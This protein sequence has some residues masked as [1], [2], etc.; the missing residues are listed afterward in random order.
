MKNILTKDFYLQPAEQ[1]AIELLGKTL[2][3]QKTPHTVL[4]GKI[5]EVEAYLGLEDPACHSFGGK[6]TP[7]TQ[8]LYQDA[9]HTYVYLIYGMYHCMNFITG[10]TQTPE[11]VLIRA[12]QPQKG[13]TLMR[14][15]RKMAKNQPPSSIAQGP[16]RLCK[17][18]GFDLTHNGWNLQDTSLPSLTVLDAKPLAMSYIC[19][20]NRV[21]IQNSGDATFWPLRFSIKDNPCVSNPPKS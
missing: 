9:G 14:E 1:V 4:S 7:R 12:I 17:A 5:V 18:F 15:N 13:Q 16:G 8:H 3:Y 6:K 10:D 2:V 19:Q 21:G 11:A 20:T